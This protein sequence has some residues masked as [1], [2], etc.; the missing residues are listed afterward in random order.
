MLTADGSLKNV[1]TICYR[2]NIGEPPD[3]YGQCRDRDE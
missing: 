1:Y 2:Q 3:E